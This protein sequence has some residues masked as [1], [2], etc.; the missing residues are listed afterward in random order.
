MRYCDKEGAQEMPGRETKIVALVLGA[1]LVFFYGGLADRMKLFAHSLIT[2]AIDITQV[3]YDSWLID[4][5]NNKIRWPEPAPDTSGITRHITGQ[6]HNDHILVTTTHDRTARLRNRQGKTVHR[7]HVPVAKAWPAQ[8]H[9]NALFHLPPRYF[10]LRDAHLFADGDL[11]TLVHAGGITPWGVGLAKI[12]RN[13]KLHWSYKGHIN[14]DFEI[15][16]NGRIYVI[17]HGKSRQWPAPV[18]DFSTPYLE[19]H[20]VIISPKGKVQKRIS[21]IQA[22]AESPYAAALRRIEESHD[23]DPTHANSINYVN[24]ATNKADT[25]DWLDNGDLIISLRNIALMLVLDP[26][27]GTI[28]YASGLPAVM[29]HDIDLLPGG[30]LLMF[31]NRG[32][33]NGTAYSRVIEMDP[34][35]KAIEWSF[36]A[37]PEGKELD[38][39]FFGENERLENG[40]TMIVNARQGEVLTVDK[41]GRP[42]W[43]FT[44]PLRKDL[45]GKAH[46]PIITHAEFIEETG[47]DFSFNAGANGTK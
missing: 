23:G 31:D 24:T 21:L 12:G 44:T 9:I 41:Q 4:S 11:L 39:K 18:R 32:D 15:G 27:T 37:T 8:D 14:N 46:R 34:V 10:Y 29:Q 22:L 2:P 3:V 47:I 35:T 1:Y 7:W 38:S 19:D 25:P 30:N 45:D 40:D 17:E 42:L 16:P 28:K 43:Q 6:I 20:I 13:S 26:E 33:T 36:S 5:Y